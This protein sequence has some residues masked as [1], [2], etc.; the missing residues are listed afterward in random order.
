MNKRFEVPGVDS[1]TL[2]SAAAPAILESKARPLFD[3]EAAARGGADMDAVHDMRVASRR[4]REAM[5]L[6]EPLYPRKAYRSWYRRVRTITRALGPVRDSDVFIDEF[7][8]KGESLGE[9][10][11]RAI[12]FLVGFRMGQRVHELAMLNE[13]L[14]GLDLERNR[15]SFTEFAG[16]LD[17]QEWEHRALGDF[18]HAAVQERGRIVVEAQPVA[19]DPINIEEQ[20]ALRID[21]KQL[22]YAVEA[23][24][25]CYGDAFDGLHQTLTAFQDALG[26]MHDVHIF[27]DMLRDPERIEAAS[28][29]G[30]S[31]EDLGEVVVDLEDR[32]RREFKRFADLAAKH[33]AER[34]V[35][36]LLTPLEH[37]EVAEA[38]AVDDSVEER[39]VIEALLAHEELPVA[40]LVV[41][42]DEPWEEGWDH[43]EASVPEVLRGTR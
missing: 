6:L 26:D 8:R 11:R 13:T 33:P 7:S 34:L 41:V 16:Q 1:R 30:V 18:A 39:G 35:H 29:A 31:A 14:A 24:A 20:H 2:L 15:G 9:G 5:R 42:G 23:F 40:A 10:G 36:T 3:L 21:Y 37:S 38:V 4:L 43:G 32:A 19:L 12:A 28:R 25:P 27:L 22:R 17:A